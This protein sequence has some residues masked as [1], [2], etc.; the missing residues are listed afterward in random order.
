M[1]I[2]FTHLYNCVRKYSS[3]TYSATPATKF[4]GASENFQATCRVQ[5]MK[6]MT[7]AFMEFMVQQ[8]NRLQPDIVLQFSPQYQCIANTTFLRRH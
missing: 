5:R 3:L 8:G 2:I 6:K 1:I 4:Y 7:T